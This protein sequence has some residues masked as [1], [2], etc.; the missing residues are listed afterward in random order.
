[1]YAL[2]PF[3]GDKQ[4]I[5]IH[6]YSV[7]QMSVPE[8]DHLQ[9]LAGDGA[10]FLQLWHTGRVSHPDLQPDGA[11]RVSASAICLDDLVCTHDRQKPHVTPRALR[12]YTV[13]GN[14]SPVKTLAQGGVIESIRRFVWTLLQPFDQMKVEQ[15]EYIQLADVRAES[16]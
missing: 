3:V 8:R 13:V 2:Q 14:V 4:R 1:M 9:V 16:L 15:S 11:T 5:Y 12:N 7:A 6:I 10:T